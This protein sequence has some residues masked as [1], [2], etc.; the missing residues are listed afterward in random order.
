MDASN[1]CTAMQQ[2]DDAAELLGEVAGMPFQV[3]L[4]QGPAMPAAVLQDAIDE[5][6][7][8]GKE[9]QQLGMA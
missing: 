5:M 2:Y 6:R 9:H 3:Q 1:A 7:Q 8:A 4:G